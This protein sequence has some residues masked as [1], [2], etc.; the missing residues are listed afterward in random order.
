MAVAATAAE[1]IDVDEA[2]LEAAA[3]KAAK[4]S[5]MDADI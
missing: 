2:A 3:A 4:K 1:D 5:S